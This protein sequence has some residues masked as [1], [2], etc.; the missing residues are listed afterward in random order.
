LSSPVVD[1][2]LWADTLNSI[3]SVVVPKAVVVV[4]VAVVAESEI[5][6]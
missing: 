3:D 1:E 5:V 2:L 6:L 4:N